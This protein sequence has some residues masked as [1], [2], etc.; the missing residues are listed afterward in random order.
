M[1]LLADYKPTQSKQFYAHELVSQFEVQGIK[2][3]KKNALFAT[4]IFIIDQNDE[5]LENGKINYEFSQTVYNLNFIENDWDGEGAIAPSKNT[6]TKG[7]SIISLLTEIGQEIHN[8][9]YGV[10]GEI[11]IDIRN[12]YKSIE[13]LFYPNRSKYVFLDTLTNYGEQGSFESGTLY[14]ILSKLNN[15]QIMA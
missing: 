4:N 6:I 14:T 15:G 13:I 12:G 3:V 9:D 7:L 10:E 2:L 1:P 8:V 5:P 11:L